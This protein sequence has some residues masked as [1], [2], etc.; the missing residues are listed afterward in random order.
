[1]K[2]KGKFLFF[3]LLISAVTRFAGWAQKPQRR[4]PLPAQLEI[5][6]AQG[7]GMPPDGSVR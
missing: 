7:D 6:P 2:N 3:S 4:R 5:S 1:M